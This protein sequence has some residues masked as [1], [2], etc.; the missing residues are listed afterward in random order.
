MSEKNTSHSF[1]KQWCSTP[2]GYEATQAKRWLKVPTKILCETRGQLPAL[3]IHQRHHVLRI[4]SSGR[5]LRRKHFINSAQIFLAQLHV[6]RTHIL[7]QIFPPLGSRDRH[8]VFP[9]RQH[10]SQRQLRRLAP[11]L[12]RNLLHAPHEIEILL[13]ILSLKPRTIPP[14]IILW[15]IFEAPKLPRQEPASQRAIS[16]KADPQLATGSQYLSLGVPRPQRTAP[17]S[18]RVKSSTTRP[19]SGLISFSSPAACRCK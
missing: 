3:S 15:Q 19:S 5:R 13:K 16:H 8:K 6:K 11:F 12:F 18:N 10:P 7:L 2:F 14:V 9:L 1:M 4:P 17:G